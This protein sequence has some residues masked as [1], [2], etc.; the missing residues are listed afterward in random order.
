LGACA[1]GKR[2]GAS[3][4]QLQAS[5][6]GKQQN[7]AN[8]TFEGLEFASGSSNLPENTLAIFGQKHWANNLDGSH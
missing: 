8:R 1:A 2:S 4:W 7:A 6:A 5:V 3:A